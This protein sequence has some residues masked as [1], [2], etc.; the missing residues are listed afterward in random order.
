VRATTP[1]LTTLRETGK[2]VA[3]SVAAWA[4]ARPLLASF[5]ATFAVC[6]ILTRTVDRPLV[7]Y[8]RELRGTEFH[9]LSLQITDL[10]EATWWLVA[11]VL[12]WGVLRA[13][14]AT[15]LMV[16]TEEK[17]KRL[18]LGPAFFI[19]SYVA[20][21]GVLVVAKILFG[22][23]R[24]KFYWREDIYGFSPLNFA[25]PDLSFPSGHTQTIFAFMVAL[26]FLF[27]RLRIAFLGLAVVIGL[28]RVG[29]N[30]HYLSDVVMGA[31]VGIVVTILVH[32]AFVRR[33]GPVDMVRAWRG[34]DEGKPDGTIGRG[35]ASVS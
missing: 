21:A 29:T 4:R 14:A 5:A 1:F 27:P 3:D 25:Y 22:R 12:V 7:M 31:Y 19:A 35:P 32:R 33:W 11:A 20:S 34:Q 16:E 9:R 17:F 30:A 24:P 8:M 6:L 28:S 10:G 2:N 15:T 23:W 13:I 26:S 18:A